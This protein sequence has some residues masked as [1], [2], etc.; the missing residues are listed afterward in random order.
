MKVVDEDI[1]WVLDGLLVQTTTLSVLVQHD[2][3]TEAQMLKI[4]LK[5][6]ESL[7][8]PSVDES[9]VTFLLIL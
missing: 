3:L 6:L 8:A 2:G 1:K 5:T 9:A 4:Y 7:F